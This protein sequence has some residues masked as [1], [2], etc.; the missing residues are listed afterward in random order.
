MDDL[1]E[2]VELSSDAS[3]TAGRE[4]YRMGDCLGG[5]VCM[6]ITVGVVSS[7]DIE[8]QALNARRLGNTA[9]TE[10]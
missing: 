6:V 2:M 3:G 8:P 4:G 5:R 7:D 1:S 10:W 9:N